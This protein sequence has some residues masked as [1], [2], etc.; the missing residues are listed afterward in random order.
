VTT[1]VKSRSA[2]SFPPKRWKTSYFRSEA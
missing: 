2:W 1:A